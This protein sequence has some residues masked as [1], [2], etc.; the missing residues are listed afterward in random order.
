MQSQSSMT[1]PQ[2]DGKWHEVSSSNIKKIRYNESSETLGIEFQS[3]VSWVY[4]DVPE[5]VFEEFATSDSI[6][7]AFHSMIRNQFK[8][9]KI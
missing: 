9:K 7:K 5:N 3:G 8:A 6:G 4:E 2:P 1:K